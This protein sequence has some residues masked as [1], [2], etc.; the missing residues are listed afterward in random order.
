MSAVTLIARDE[1]RLMRRN[2]VAVVAFALLVLL[3]LAAALIS[4]SHQQSITQTRARFQAQAAKEFETQPDRHPHRMVHFGNFVFRPLGLLAA[5]DPGVDAFTGNSMFLEG[6]RQNS[7]N[8]GDVRQSSMLVRFGQ[9]TP[10]FVLQVIAP[11]LLIFLGYGAVA[12]ERERGTLRQ[13][14]VQGVSARAVVMGKLLAL[15]V[16]AALVGLP[17]MIAFLLIAGQPGALAGPMLVI[18]L[19]YAAY[20]ALWAIIVI[21]MSAL[22]RRGRDALLALLALWVVLVILLPRI[23]PDVAA[24]AH[25]LPTRLETDIAIA[26]DLH[27]LGDSHNPDDPFFKAF[28]E[29]TLRQYGVTRVEDLP[30][31]YSGLLAMEGEKLTSGLFDDYADRSFAIQAAQTRLNDGF[32]IISPAIALKRLSMAAAGTDLTGHRRFMTQAEAYRYDMVQRLNRLQAEAVSY[33][34]DTA[35]DAGADRRKR[36]SAGHWETI[37]QFQFKPARA[38]DLVKASLPGLGLL[39]AWLVIAALALLPVARHLQKARP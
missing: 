15:G 35:K 29:K 14:L 17:A 10:A 7:A 22:A 33:A 24:Q 21:L 5:F 30:V 11:L 36:I 13:M 19:G 4:W 26:R 34:N 28:K 37:P 39:L 8:F 23:A 9:L 12:R 16:V 3:T 25:A 2:R 32:G 20:L 1:L 27:K 38:A 6:H 31:N 18:A